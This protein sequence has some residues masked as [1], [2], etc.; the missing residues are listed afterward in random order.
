MNNK[1]VNLLGMLLLGLATAT[2]A[3]PADNATQ[4]AVAALEDKW[5]QAEKAS[6]PDLLAPLLAS[7]FINIGL[8][9][10]Q[11]DRTKTLAE[12]KAT[13]YASIDVKE[14]HVTVF[15]N[16]AVAS[17]LFKATATDEHGKALNVNA[18][19]ADTWVK[20]PDGSWQCVLSQGSSLSP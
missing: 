2:Q 7:K 18:R 17:M 5:T 4:K 16:T 9:G 19:W 12:T 6:D 11:T 8:D 10:K 14:F 3:K 1:N 13:K 20:M 15:G